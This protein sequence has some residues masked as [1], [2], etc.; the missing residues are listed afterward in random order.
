MT[1]WLGNCPRLVCE[2]PPSGCNRPSPA[3]RNHR[4]NVGQSWKS[5]CRTPLS[6]LLEDTSAAG[7]GAP[8]AECRADADCGAKGGRFQDDDD[9]GERPDRNEDVSAFSVRRPSAERQSELPAAKATRLF[10]NGA[11]SFLI[12]SPF[13]G[14]PTTH[15][16]T[17]TQSDNRATSNLGDDS[18]AVSRRLE[19]PDLQRLL[20]ELRDLVRIQETSR[21]EGSE[22]RPIPLGPHGTADHKQWLLALSEAI[23]HGSG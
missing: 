16:A 18:G 11:Q 19:G 22:P 13:P 8:D 2:P 17:Q 4:I 9:R 14:L 23:M 1:P 3:R 6:S 12:D 5:W 15:A 20:A 10:V 21:F 7:I